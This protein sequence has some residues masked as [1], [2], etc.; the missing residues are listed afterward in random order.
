MSVSTRDSR[1][2]I[3]SAG[4]G[5]AVWASDGPQISINRSLTCRGLACLWLPLAERFSSV[6]PLP[7]LNQQKD[8]DHVM[9][10]INNIVMFH[11]NNINRVFPTS[12]FMPAYFLLFLTPSPSSHPFAVSFFSIQFSFTLSFKF[13][14][15]FLLHIL[16]PLFVISFISLFS[17]VTI[18]FPRQRRSPF[19]TCSPRCAWPPSTRSSPLY[20]ATTST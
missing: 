6:L 2:A 19:I 14:F 15:A 18:F 11:I 1:F 12:N 10:H 9:F 16:H 5:H 8:L 17:F 20:F 7:Q 13:S 4:N 3:R